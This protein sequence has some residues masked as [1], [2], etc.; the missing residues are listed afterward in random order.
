[1]NYKLN[2][3]VRIWHASK[4]DGK[5]VRIVP[6]NINKIDLFLEY[7]VAH[8]IISNQAQKTG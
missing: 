4:S 3:I 8:Q 1:M 6:G 5:N 7:E 2:L